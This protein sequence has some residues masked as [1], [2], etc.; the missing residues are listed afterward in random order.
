MAKSAKKA[1]KRTAKPAV[2]KQRAAA[3][4]P[5]AKDAAKPAPAAKKVTK[6]STKSGGPRSADTT[7]KPAKAAGKTTILKPDTKT[8]K[9]DPKAKAQPKPTAKTAGAKSTVV[10]VEA[11]PAA[12]Q[13]QPKQAAAP[14]SAPPK[15]DTP[16]PVAAKDSAAKP[17]PKV[18]V[19]PPITFLP[20]PAIPKRKPLIPSGPKNKAADEPVDDRPVLTKTPFNKK[21]LARYKEILLAKREVLI[22]D[23]SE[24]ERGALNAESGSL[25]S[26]PQH[27]ADQGSDASDQDV[28]LNLAAQDRVLIKEIDAALKRIENG[29]FGLCEETGKPIRPERLEELPW[30]RFSIEAARANERRMYFR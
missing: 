12:K 27:M 8:A 25:S 1:E 18:K 9:E 3:P 22:G 29:T 24:I 6:P 23:L 15:S 30:A 21:E 19:K 14:K 26:L 28:S 20:M 11:K 16:K 13:V 10:K 5:K 17:G 2:K 4:A 7:S